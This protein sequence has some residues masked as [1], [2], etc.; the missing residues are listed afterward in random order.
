MNVG[1]DID[2]VQ[3]EHIVHVRGYQKKTGG[4]GLPSFFSLVID[5][6]PPR[7]SHDRGYYEQDRENDEKG[8]MDAGFSF[9][10]SRNMVLL[11]YFAVALNSRRSPTMAAVGGSPGRRT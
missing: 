2:V 5:R 11:V 8:S 10:G 9:P 7:R 1:L 6:P 3:A 4:A